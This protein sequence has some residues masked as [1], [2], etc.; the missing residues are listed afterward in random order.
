[1]EV[2]RKPKF[3]YSQD[4]RDRRGYSPHRPTRRS[5][6]RR[7]EVRRKHDHHVYSDF[8]R[9]GRQGKQESVWLAGLITV[10]ALDW[11]S[12]PQLLLALG[13]VRPRN[14]VPRSYGQAGKVTLDD[15]VHKAVLCVIFKNRQ[16]LTG[17]LPP[18]Q[19]S[20]HHHHVQQLEYCLSF[21][22]NAL[23][24]PRQNKGRLAAF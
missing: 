19:V 10:P 18:R 1:M 2:G 17:T 24:A 8:P 5:Y 9:L 23:Q 6:H 11:R 21:K 16:S 20:E 4:S 13:W 12:G 15:Q 7:T 22:G 3:W 14:I